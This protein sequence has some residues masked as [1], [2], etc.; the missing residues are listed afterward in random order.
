MS[1]KKPIAILM[2]AAMTMAALSAVSLYAD[3]VARNNGKPVTNSGEVIRANDNTPLAE[4]QTAETTTLEADPGTTATTAKEEGLGGGNQ[5]LPPANPEGGENEPAAPQPTPPADPF[6]TLSAGFVKGYLD[7]PDAPSSLKGD[8][9]KDFTD[10]MSCVSITGENLSGANNDLVINVSAIVGDMKVING[11][12]KAYAMLYRFDKNST[13]T[14]TSGYNLTTSD[15][16]DGINWKTANAPDDDYQYIM[17]W[18]NASTVSTAITFREEKTDSNNKKVITSQKVTVVRRDTTPVDPSATTTPVTTAPENLVSEVSTDWPLKATVTDRRGTLDLDGYK[19]IIEPCNEVYLNSSRRMPE[20]VSAIKD[21]KA[22]A[23]DITLERNGTSRDFTSLFKVKMALPEK[24][25]NAKDVYLYKASSGGYSSM[26]IAE[27]NGGE[28]SFSCYDMGI[29]I[30]VSSVRLDGYS[31][32]TTTGTGTNSPGTAS[33]SITGDSS[34]ALSGAEVRVYSDVTLPNQTR[35]QITA[36]DALDTSNK[37]VQVAV[38]QGKALPYDISLTSNG[39]AI[40]QTNIKAISVRFNAP[41]QFN[42]VSPLYVYRLESDNTLTNMNAGI[43][44]GV[45]SFVTAHLSTY[46][47]SSVALDGSTVITD[48]SGNVVTNPPVTTK[49]PSGGNSGGSDVT[50]PGDKNDN[51]NTGFLLALVPVGLAGAGIV[52]TIKKKR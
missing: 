46:I 5:I 52:F 30:I 7:M 2:A 49:K 48:N 18:Y 9:I 8:S 27:I 41:S 38:S 43:S 16:N 34:S 45:I 29:R 24:I 33:P 4:A 11:R 6:N 26:D 3:D 36:L 23:Y 31:S 13:I 28:Y 44:G 51:V 10:N 12:P 37:M 22:F 40:S 47:I 14:V 39:T 15:R 25:K 32:E 21:D 17:V 50:R 19:L 1:S 20:L 35:L 42:G